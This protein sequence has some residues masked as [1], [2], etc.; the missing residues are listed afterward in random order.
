MQWDP[1]YVLDDMSVDLL[2]LALEGRL[3]AVDPDRAKAIKNRR[4]PDEDFAERMIN[5]LKKQIDGS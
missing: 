2:A 1:E 5:A 3:E 4:E